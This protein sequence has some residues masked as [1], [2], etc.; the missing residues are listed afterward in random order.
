[1]SE[2]EKIQR[3]IENT[4]IKNRGMYCMRY[5]EAAGLHTFSRTDLFGALCLAFDYG[6]AKGYRAAKNAYKQGEEASA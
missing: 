2:I 1:M 5:C 3:Y 6:M 4:K